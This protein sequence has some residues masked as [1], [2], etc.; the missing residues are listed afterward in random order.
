MGRSIKKGPVVQA[1][2]MKHVEAM[3]ASG[4]KQVIKDVYKRQVPHRRKCGLYAR[5]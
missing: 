1:A 4:K 3:N 2:L 5:R